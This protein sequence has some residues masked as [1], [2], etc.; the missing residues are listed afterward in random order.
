MYFDIYLFFNIYK[1]RNFNLEYPGP[2]FLDEP[3][4]RLLNV[5]YEKNE[6]NI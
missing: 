1:K 4:F 6:K 2:I 5:N 3:R